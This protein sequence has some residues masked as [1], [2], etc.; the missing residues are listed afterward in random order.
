MKTKTKNKR[1]EEL[2]K[3]ER[4]VISLRYLVLVTKQK[5]LPEGGIGC[6]K[7]LRTLLIYECGNTNHELI[8]AK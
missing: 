1:S 6:L 4:Y 8:K 7:F 2:P 5:R 3:D